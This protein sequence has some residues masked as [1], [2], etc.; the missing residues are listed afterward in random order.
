MER[1]VCPG[2]QGLESESG[3][4]GDVGSRPLEMQGCLAKLL[5]DMA[6]CSACQ[7]RIAC[8]YK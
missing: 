5:L 2:G 6:T 8:L 7:K 4:G 3:F 1:R